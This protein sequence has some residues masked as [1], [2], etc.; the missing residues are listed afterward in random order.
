MHVSAVKRNHGPYTCEVY[1][2]DRTFPSIKSFKNHG[3]AHSSN[4]P[5]ECDRCGKLFLI[6]YYFV[7]HLIDCKRE[8]R[9]KQFI[10]Q[11]CGILLEAKLDLEHH[12]QSVQ[13]NGGPAHWIPE[14]EMH[15]L[16]LLRRGLPFE[17]DARIMGRS[18]A[19]L[20][21]QYRILE[22][23]E[24]MEVQERAKRIA[25]QQMEER[26]HSEG[27]SDGMGAHNESWFKAIVG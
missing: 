2:C 6:H 26:V 12:F 19:C 16:Q 21:A 20:T 22:T 23:R 27:G 18:E 17:R 9:N 25:A 11:R 5:M 4:L 10:P 3:Y 1:S 14:E 15:F 7:Q 24:K 13:H 8:T